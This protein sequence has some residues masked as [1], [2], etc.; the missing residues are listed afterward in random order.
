MACVTFGCKEDFKTFKK[1]K[2]VMF[3]KGIDSLIIPL[4]NL[5]ALKYSNGKIYVTNIKKDWDHHHLNRILRD[6]GKIL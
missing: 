4:K 5:K 3:V 1:L 6:Y 2:Y